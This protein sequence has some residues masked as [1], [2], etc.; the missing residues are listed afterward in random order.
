MKNP[1]SEFLLKNGFCRI[2]KGHYL[3]ANCEIWIFESSF[4]I[5]HIGA[6]AD[7]PDYLMIHEL[8]KLDLYDNE[9]E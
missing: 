5:I 2:E 6:L 1:I 7:L 4:K 9:L 8:I 3:N